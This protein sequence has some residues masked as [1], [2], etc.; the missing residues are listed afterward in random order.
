MKISKKRRRMLSGEKTGKPVISM[1]FGRRW[2]SKKGKRNLLLSVRPL[3]RLQSGVP[4]ESRTSDRMFCFPLD[5]APFRKIS[6]KIQAG[7]EMALH[8]WERHSKILPNRGRVEARVSANRP[9]CRRNGELSAGR[10]EISAVCALHPAA[11]YRNRRA[12]PARPPLC[13][14]TAHRRRNFLCIPIPF[15]S[16]IGAQPPMS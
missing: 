4:E 15:P 6:G 16:A 5:F 11:A 1:A 3:V 10:K 13:G 9:Q 7:K 14:V 8:F 12:V 2:Q